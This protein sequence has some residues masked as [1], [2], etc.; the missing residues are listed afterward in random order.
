MSKN[1]PSVAYTPMII[2]REWECPCP[3][4]QPEG[5][6]TPNVYMPNMKVRPMI[7]SAM[8]R[9]SRRFASDIF[10][11]PNGWQLVRL[12]GAR[13]ERPRRRTTEHRDEL[14]PPHVEHAAPPALPNP[15]KRS[16]PHAEAAAEA[17]AGPWGRP[18]LF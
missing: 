15:A 3:Q 16:L 6:R 17:P 9:K 13:R 11:S 10:A 5:Q 1:T 18:E 2:I 7:I 8:R 12:L 4:A 14:A